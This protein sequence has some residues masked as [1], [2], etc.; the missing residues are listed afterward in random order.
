[1]K[2]KKYITLSAV[3]IQLCILMIDKKIALLFGAKLEELELS[4]DGKTGVY[5]VLENIQLKKGLTFETDYEFPKGLIGAVELIDTPYMADV[6]PLVT[7]DFDTG[8]PYMT[9]ADGATDEE[10]FEEEADPDEDQPEEDEDPPEEEIKKETPAE[11]TQPQELV[12]PF[13]P[14]E[15]SPNKKNKKNKKNR[16]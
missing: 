7:E 4:E 5:K 12:M 1:M 14:A 15:T 6:I 2:M 3:V 16:G 11:A 8:S 10:A 13:V 9:E